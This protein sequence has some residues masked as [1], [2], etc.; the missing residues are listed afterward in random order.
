MRYA[1]DPFVLRRFADGRIFFVNPR[2]PFEFFLDC[3]QTENPLFLISELEDG[4][5]A[6]TPNAWVVPHD[7]LTAGFGPRDL[8]PTEYEYVTIKRA[9]YPLIITAHPVKNTLDW[10]RKFEMKVK[11]F[12][13]QTLCEFVT[14]S[15]ETVPLQFK[16]KFEAA[17]RTPEEIEV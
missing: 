7:M 2:M 4:R 3:F 13:E 5:I 17:I 14:A 16:K 1:Y 11:P 9:M 15:F 6:I 8:L 10:F 12:A